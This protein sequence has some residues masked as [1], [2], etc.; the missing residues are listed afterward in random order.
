LD[1]PA[2]T[3]QTQNR[4]IEIRE[5]NIDSFSQH[6]N[7]MN[8]D[9]SFKFIR[10]FEE[11]KQVGM[12]QDISTSIKP[13]NRNL[14][15]YPNILPYE[16]SRVKLNC[17]ESNSNS[18]YINANYIPGYNREKEYIATQEPLQSTKHDFWRM[19][20][21]E[22][23]KIIVMISE[24]EQRKKINSDHYWPLN[25]GPLRMQDFVVTME[26]EETNSGWTIRY[27]S[28]YNN[29]TKETRKVQQFQFKSIPDSDVQSG[30]KAL[31][32]FVQNV[33]A[34]INETSSGP[35]VVHCSSA[36]GGSIGVFIATDRLLQ[37]LADNKYVDVYGFVNEMNLH[38][39]YLF[40]S[41]DEYIFLHKM[42]LDCLNGSYEDINEPI[43]QTV[44]EPHYENGH[45]NL[46]MEQN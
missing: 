20:W 44:L 25:D 37:Q 31:V 13:E 24:C 15:R 42:V 26:T 33:R 4:N 19:I 1:K 2:I 17:K 40:Q 16:H 9:A 23:T 46:S 5:I 45:I 21:Q 35:I 11:L 38:R 22:K 39:M 32:Q 41:V 12:N 10:E 43:Y 14:N 36:S 30:T 28:L 18:D 7:D 6:F 3:K 34:C 8:A 27:F 29:T